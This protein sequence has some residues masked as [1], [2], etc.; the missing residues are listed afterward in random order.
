MESAQA[1]A[2]AVRE[3]GVV[4]EPGLFLFTRQGK[5]RTK[6]GNSKGHSRTRMR[7]FRSHRLKVAPL[8]LFALACQFMLAFAHVHPDRLAGNSSQWAVAAAAAT[9]TPADLP[10][11]PR[12]NNPSGLGGDFCAVCANIS[13][14]GA[15]VVP[16]TPAVPPG[17][18]FFNELHRPFAATAAASIDLFHFNARG[19][20]RA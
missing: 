19:P 13:L 12:P 11:S 14:A 20:P 8:A 4:A 10:S 6:S 16:A 9:V 18:S 3:K 7:W 17:I 1:S 5:G 2:A 15:L